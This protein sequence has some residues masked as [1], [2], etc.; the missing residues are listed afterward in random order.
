MPTVMRPTTHSHPS[1][2]QEKRPAITRRNFAQ[3]TTIGLGFILVL[4]S[5]CGLLYPSFAGLHLS[6][7]H[8]TSLGLCG[9]LAFWA[10]LHNDLRKNFIVDMSLGLFFFFHALAGFLLGAPGRP[11][12]GFEAMDPMLVKIMPGFN[13]LGR[14]D[15]IFHSL[16]T[17][18]FFLA[19]RFLWK[20]YRSLLRRT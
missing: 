5:L 3:S 13:E 16:L 6:A 1:S 2:V 20:H 9:I 14:N 8:A 12:V 15:H 17:I 18:G 10:G 19:A 11:G 4:M 7:M